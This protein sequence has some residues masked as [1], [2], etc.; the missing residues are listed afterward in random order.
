MTNHVEYKGYFFSTGGAATTNAAITTVIISVNASTMIFFQRV[1]QIDCK[2][3]DHLHNVLLHSQ[4]KEWN[5]NMN[6]EIRL[7][8]EIK[9]RKLFC[10]VDSKR[11]IDDEEWIKCFTFLGQKKS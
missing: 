4:R 3:S 10:T 1:N 6:E 7:H 2:K 8:K 9:K 11:V 5:Q